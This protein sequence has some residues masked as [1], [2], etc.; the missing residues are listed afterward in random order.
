MKNNKW[1][2][3]IELI[4]VISIIIIVS[5]SWVL[6]FSHFVDSQEIKQES[7]MILDT[8][9][10]L[11]KEIKNNNILDYTIKFDTIS[12]YLVYSA[13][14]NSHI[15]NTPAHINFLSHTGVVLNIVSGTWSDIWNIKTY[16]KH[17]KQENIVL[18]GDDIYQYNFLYSQPYTIQSQLNDTSINTIQIIPYTHNYNSIEWSMRLIWI[19]NRESWGN[20]YS[21]LTLSNIDGKQKILW[22]NSVL[23][24]AFLSFEK[25]WQ[26]YTLAIK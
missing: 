9:N 25:K 23:S 16:K 24:Q 12:W 14:I 19:S 21:R 20:T 7:Q 5:G 15:L 22:D 6:Y 13:S 10:T 17:K 11:D 4:I 26:T 8:I 1:F 2:S 18:T 3:L